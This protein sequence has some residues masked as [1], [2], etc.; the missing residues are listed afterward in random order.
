MRKQ[1]PGLSVLIAPCAIA[2]LAQSGCGAADD[3]SAGDAAVGLEPPP[4]CAL[5]PP[6]DGWSYPTG[7][8]GT[9]VGDTFERF[10]LEDCDGDPVDF[11]DILA[12]AD[13]VLF[14]IGAGWCQPCVEESQT[15]DREI[16]REFCPRGL[17]VVQV[18]FQD[19]QSRPATG[20]FCD[21]WRN[22]F[23]LS[24]PVLK[25]P[26]FTT[27]GHFESVQSQTPVNLL[28]GPDGTILFKE[29][30]TPGNDLPER[31]DMLLS[32]E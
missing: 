21:N 7:P 20:L 29:T 26:L 16:F 15:L 3:G 14:N 11:G 25:D 6:P 23:G 22:S 19:E 27:A 28:V 12:Q 30:G 4:E 24:F 9:E 8:Y 31:I 5:G 10:T 17:R 2:L 13:L 1:S 32:G 18:L